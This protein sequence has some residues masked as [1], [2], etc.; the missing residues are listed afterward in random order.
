MKDIYHDN[1]LAVS[2]APQSTSSDVTGNTV[3][4]QGFEAVMFNLYYGDV[5]DGESASF[6][7]Q[8]SDDNSNWSD[9]A[10]ADLLG[11]EPSISGTTGDESGVSKVGYIGNKRY[12]RV[13]LTAPTTGKPFSGIAVKSH[14]R[15]DPQ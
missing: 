1:A 8:E 12:V 3:D 10:D 4:L 5:A 2:I 11:S 15:H 7:V 13:N 6:T 9:V 14:A